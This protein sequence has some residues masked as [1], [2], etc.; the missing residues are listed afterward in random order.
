[1]LS[2]MFLF[3]PEW[4]ELPNFDVF[5]SFPVVADGS[6]WLCYSSSL[7]STSR[8]GLTPVAVFL[9]FW[10]PRNYASLDLGCGPFLK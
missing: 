6:S 3:G 4:T 9:V 8:P 10:H 2:V 7:T 1:M 5:G